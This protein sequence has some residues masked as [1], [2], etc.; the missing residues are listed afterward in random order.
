M[1][2]NDDT[3]VSTLLTNK[4]YIDDLKEFAVSIIEFQTEMGAS[5]NSKNKTNLPTFAEN[6]NRVHYSTMTETN[7][8]LSFFVVLA[9]QST[10]TQSTQ[11]NQQDIT[12][13]FVL[14]Q[15]NKL[16]DFELFQTTQTQTF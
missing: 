15:L 4:M 13:Q 1:T 7:A 6:L 12:N 9:A 14:S 8:L 2:D 3:K 16:K 5:S 11:T 10:S